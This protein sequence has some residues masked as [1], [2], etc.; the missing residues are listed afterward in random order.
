M[1]M[2]EAKRAFVTATA[3]Q[4]FLQN[5]VSSVTIRDVAEA[6][7]IGEATIY[8]YFR[9][10]TSL[11]VAC[12]VKLQAEVGAQFMDFTREKDG[13]SQL[14]RFYGAY[15]KL[16]SRRPE[17]YR[18]LSEFDAYCISSG[19]AELTEY[20]DNFDRF[21]SSVLEA[22]EK[23]LADGSVK[24][25]DDPVLFYQTSTHALLSLCK[26]LAAERRIVRQDAVIDPNAEIRTLTEL[27]LAAL[28][29]KQEESL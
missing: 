16:F 11:I 25:Q 23:G 6:S 17:L 4:L 13:F 12:A 3:T 24:G 27:I 28:K 21:Q 2:Q 15:E 9:N 18:F 19:E 1:T 20:Q 26:K 29:N 7:G 8:R 22:Y 5:S 10:R 14:S